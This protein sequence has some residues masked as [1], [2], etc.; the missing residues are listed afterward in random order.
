MEID[1][2]PVGIPMEVFAHVDYLEMNEETR[3]GEN[4]IGDWLS[5]VKTAP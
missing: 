2:G 4:D 5:A 1:S 3:S